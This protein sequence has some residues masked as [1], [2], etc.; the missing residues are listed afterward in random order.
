[1]Q[2]QTSM[3]PLHAES[4][5]AKRSIKNTSPFG[6]TI[7]LS[8]AFNDNDKWYTGTLRD[9]YFR[10]YVK[11]DFDNKFSSKWKS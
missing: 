11:N 10:F 2:N 5:T 6:F 7:S 4:L 8:I 1:M 9:S 3:F